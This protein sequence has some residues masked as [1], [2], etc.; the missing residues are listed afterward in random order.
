VARRVATLTFALDGSWKDRGTCAPK[1][2]ASDEN[3]ILFQNHINVIRP[4]LLKEIASIDARGDTSEVMIPWQ[5][6]NRH[7]DFGKALA[8]AAHDIVPDGVVVEQITRNQDEVHLVLTGYCSNS[9][10]GPL[11]GILKLRPGSGGG[12]IERFAD[13]KVSC[14][15]EAGHEL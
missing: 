7:V 6:V 3:R 4:S 13:L 15:K 12:P 8:G 1:P 9:V 14:V 2:S 5:N 10:D 11:A